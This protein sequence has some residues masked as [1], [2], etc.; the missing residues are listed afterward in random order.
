MELR[1][2]V[3]RVYIRTYP[4]LY[5]AIKIHDGQNF[6]AKRTPTRRTRRPLN[7]TRRHTTSSDDI[8][9]GK[10]RS[11]RLFGRE[12]AREQTCFPSLTT[13]LNDSPYISSYL[14]RPVSLHSFALLRDADR[15]F[16]S[17]EERKSKGKLLVTPLKG[18]LVD[19]GGAREIQLFVA[20]AR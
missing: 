7:V 11:L 5:H 3:T 1:R 17:V 9:G 8:T 10:T 2:S 15:A 13:G 16:C 12:V 6:G 19:K 20:S 4:R 14:R 18:R